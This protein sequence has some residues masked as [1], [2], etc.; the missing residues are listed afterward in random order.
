MDRVC[1]TRYDKT[2]PGLFLDGESGRKP[3]IYVHV[4]ILQTSQGRA[5]SSPK[6]EVSLG[7]YVRKITRDRLKQSSDYFKDGFFTATHT[8]QK[9]KQ[10]NCH[11]KSDMPVQLLNQPINQ[12]PARRTM[13]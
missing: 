2:S 11:A 10:G 1:Y 7:N 5:P 4:R 3:L 13:A 9:A 6:V 12:N 8:F